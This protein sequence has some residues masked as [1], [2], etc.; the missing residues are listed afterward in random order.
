MLLSILPTLNFFIMKLVFWFSVV[1]FS[2]LSETFQS[3]PTRR[4]LVYSEGFC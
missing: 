2:E 3:G 4:S 1:S